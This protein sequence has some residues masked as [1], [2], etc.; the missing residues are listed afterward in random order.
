MTTATV[1]EAH[2]SQQPPTKASLK[3]WWNHFAFAQRTKRE[4]EEKKGGAHAELERRD[5]ARLTSET[6]VGLPAPPPSV[7]FGKALA[8]SL[9][10]AHVQ[11]S[12]AAPDG[13]L[14][15]WGYIP[16]VVA[17]WYAAGFVRHDLIS[18]ISLSGLYLKEH[19]TIDDIA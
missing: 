4:A 17:K 1:N 16:V 6:L 9:Q 7:V 19:G 8:E 10:R 5:H 18:T 15:V 12:T 11:I 2:I 14:Y 13:D 3:A